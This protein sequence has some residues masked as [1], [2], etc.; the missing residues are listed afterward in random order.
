MKIDL[1]DNL[2]VS[3]TFTDCIDDVH[4]LVDSTQEKMQ[5]KLQEHFENHLANDDSAIPELKV[6]Q[7]ELDL[8]QDVAMAFERVVKRHGKASEM[9]CLAVARFNFGTNKDNFA[10]RFQS[11]ERI[12]Q[13]L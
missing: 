12:D 5:F 9:S 11:L 8:F 2:G 10:R 4:F 13:I 7:A 1:K 6:D 3:S